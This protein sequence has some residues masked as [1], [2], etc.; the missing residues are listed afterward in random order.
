MRFG[1]S[2]LKSYKTPDGHL[3]NIR[4]ETYVVYLV[5]LTGSMARLKPTHIE[6]FNAY[7]SGLKDQRD[8]VDIL[9]T[10]VQFYGRG[11]DT[12]Y[13]RV[14]IYEIEP[15]TEATFQPK[16]RTP[17]IDA[18]Y[19]TIQALERVVNNDSAAAS[20]T[21]AAASPEPLN[22]VFCIQSD[23]DDN[24]S[25]EYEWTGLQQ[26]IAEKQMRGWRLIFFGADIDPVEQAEW[27]GLAAGSAI[28]YSTDLDATRRVFAEAAEKTAS[29]A[30]APQKTAAPG[31]AADPEGPAPPEKHRLGGE[32]PQKIPDDIAV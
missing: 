4:P 18:T 5:D 19:K 31:V 25:V 1:Y 13:Q 10:L 15:L 9:F 24:A 28:S 14:P 32:Q 27:M 16:G 30:R 12:I 20:Q 7:L 3:R 11:A 26:L 22:I 17:L 6:G 8:S 2:P 23:G 21:G 29:A